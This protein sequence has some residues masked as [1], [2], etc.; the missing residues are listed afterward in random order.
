M[1]TAICCYLYP[2][3]SLVLHTAIA[4]CGC[5][6]LGKMYFQL[7]HQRTF[8]TF[9]CLLWHLWRAKFKW[10]NVLNYLHEV[11][12]GRLKTIEHVYLMP[13][14]SFFLV[15]V[16]SEILQKYAVSTVIFTTS[17]P[18]AIS[19]RMQLCPSIQLWG[20]IIKISWTWVCWNSK[21][22]I[23]NQQQ[24]VFP[25]SMLICWSLMSR[26][27]KDVTFRCPTAG[28]GRWDHYKSRT[29]S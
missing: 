29:K 4:S 25:S 21:L 9:N 3:S 6:T 8:R 17:T 15:T 16:L 1:K 7:I 22:L 24:N 19:S 20:C 5:I 13:G 2:S 23:E 26:T 18:T 28:S 14:H 12:N 10:N 27:R 11:H